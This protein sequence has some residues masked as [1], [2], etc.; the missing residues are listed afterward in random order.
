MHWLSFVVAQGVCRRLLVYVSSRRE[1]IREEQEHFEKKGR[2][3]QKKCPTWCILIRQRFSKKHSFMQI[4]THSFVD[5][6]VFAGDKGNK[7]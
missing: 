2:E 1:N 5:M 4:H 7:P 3:W 6:C